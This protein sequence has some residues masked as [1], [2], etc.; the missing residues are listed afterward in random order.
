MA[1]KPGYKQTEAG[2]IPEEW[3]VS[4]LQAACR[5][6]ITY[7]IVQ[8]G[9]HLNTGIPYIRVSDMDGPELNVDGMLRTSPSIAARFGR[10]TVEEGDLVYALRGK[11]GEVRQIRADVAGANLTQG[12]ARLSPIKK[13]L[14][15]YFLWA[16]RNPPTVRQAEIESKGTTFR[17]ITLSDLRKIKVLIPPLSEQLFIAT[18]LGD[19][20]ALLDAL[21]RLIAKKRDLKQA[22][23][24]QLLTGQTRLPGFHG[25]WVVKRLVHAGRCLRGVSYRGDSD[26]S[27]HDTAYTKRLLRSNNVQDALVVASEV[28]FVNTARVSSSQVLKN[29]DIL[30]CMANGSKALVGKAGLYSINDGYD[31]TFGAFMGCFRTDATIAHPAFVFSL[32]QTGRYRDYINNLLAGSSINNL[33]PSSIESL[34]FSFPPISEQ[35]AI[36]SLLADMDA[37]LAALEQRLAKTR[38]LKQGMM[39]ELLIGRTRLL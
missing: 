10:S 21:E 20:D 17:E 26:L 38:A 32:M 34:E 14:S 31:Y 15:D 9:P 22:S 8:C 16:L 4:T 39:Q 33:R 2:V 3:Q 25:E 27:T 19:V 6:P 29:G 11:L 5:E 30:I 23:M 1:V 28:Q 37:E 18:A 36:A 35:T 7:G 24:Q 12:T 13:V